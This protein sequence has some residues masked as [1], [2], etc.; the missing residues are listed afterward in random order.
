MKF[1]SGAAVL[2]GLLEVGHGAI[3]DFNTIKEQLPIFGSNSGA[4]TGRAA[5]RKNVV[6]ILTDDQDLHMN[7]LDYMPHIQ[8]HLIDQGTLYKRHFTTT[9]VCCP[10]RVSILTGK[11]P[12]NT[13]V[14]DLTPP[15][16]TASIVR[17]VK[18]VLM[19]GVRWIS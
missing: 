19:L 9:A 15:Y 5:K 8:R 6:F 17:L 16:G 4:G 11:A 2:F 13:N 7:S 14:T 18:S 12:H 1:I 3:L 10:A